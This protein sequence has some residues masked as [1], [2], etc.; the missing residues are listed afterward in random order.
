MPSITPRKKMNVVRLY[1]Q[2]YSYQE[3]AKRIGVAKGSTVTILTDLKNGKFYPLENISD[4]IDTLR[5]I[6]VQIRRTDLSLSQA[7]LGLTIFQGI[8]A[9]GVQP[10]EVKNFVEQIRRLTPEG[11]ETPDFLAAVT[12]V[13]EVEQR[14]GMNP[15][16]LEER[17]GELEARYHELEQRC[18]ELDPLSKEVAAL[19]EERDSLVSQRATLRLEIEKGRKTLDAEICERSERLQGLQRQTA[20]TEQLIGQLGKRVLD[21]EESLRQ[22]SYRFDQASDALDK[23]LN[24]GLSENDLPEL[25]MRLASAAYHHNIEPAQ[26]QRWLF[27]C[28]DQASSLLGLETMI[29]GRRDELIKEERKLAAARKN[30]ETLAAELKALKKQGAEEKAAQKSR[31]KAWELEIRAVGSIFTEAANAEREDIKALRHSFDQ[32]LSAQQVELQKTARALG[33]LQGE[34]DSYAW[35]RPLVNLLQGNDGVTTKEARIAA[36]FLCLGLRRYLELNV[37]NQNKPA[38]I[39]YLLGQLLEVLERWET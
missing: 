11:S 21:Q 24:L 27:N 10:A 29:K 4:E 2:G 12:A 36:T 16:Q 22:I 30:H 6:A 38:R 17:V 14:T 5:E 13:M 35:V 3:I 7:A 32:S 39:E 31:R 23:I 20:D 26:F 18:K 33:T 19:T 8:E 37:E 34:I 1:L 25:A 9:L 15:T 28:L